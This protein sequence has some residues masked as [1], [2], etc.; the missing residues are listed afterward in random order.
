MLEDAETTHSDVSGSYFLPD[1]DSDGDESFLEDDEGDDEGEDE[2][3]NGGASNEGEGAGKEGG[4]D[5]KEGAVANFPVIDMTGRPESESG[6]GGLPE[7]AVEEAVAAT[8]TTEEFARFSKPLDLFSDYHHSATFIVK[9]NGTPLYQTEAAAPVTSSPASS[10]AY[11]KIQKALYHGMHAGTGQQE[12]EQA[13]RVAQRLMDRHRLSFED[14]SLSAVKDQGRARSVLFFKRYGFQG[15]TV[16]KLPS[17]LW[18]SLLAKLVADMFNVKYY[19]QKPSGYVFYGMADEVDQA[20]A[21]FEMVSNKTV[22]LCRTKMGNQNSSFMTG[23]AEGMRLAMEKER[24]EARLRES[25][26]ESKAR[27]EWERRC[28]NM[29]SKVLSG[30]KIRL[31]KGRRSTAKVDGAARAKGVE[32]GRGQRVKQNLIK[33]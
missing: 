33:C 8:L 31:R 27:G 30:M 13:I 23:I 21:A 15:Q 11:A 6:T 16:Q 25:P 19:T 12:A 32:V 2:G 18:H 24:A 26:E 5:G 4:N 14:V 3:A 1:S 7:S 10:A 17:G 9:N 22:Y 28:A 29:S 20:S